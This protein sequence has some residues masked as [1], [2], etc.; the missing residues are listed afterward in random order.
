MGT[1]REKT[2][3]HIRTKIDENTSAMFARSCFDPQFSSMVAF[4]ALSDPL[5]TYTAAR[6]EFIGRNGTPS[7][8][9]ALLRSGMTKDTGDTIDPC[10]AMQVRFELAPG[11][12]HRI[13]IVLGAC[14]DEDEAKRLI[15]K[16]RNPDDAV[17]ELDSAARVWGDRLSLISVNTPEGTFD[18]MINGWTLYQ[19]MSSMEWRIRIPRSA[20]GCDGIRVLGACHRA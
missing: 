6:R 18:K 3:Q 19:D 14:G 4:T 13:A 20:S 1:D 9:A 7:A 11:E 5:F 10:A 15:Q 16:Y 8:P 2:Q 12:T 17:A